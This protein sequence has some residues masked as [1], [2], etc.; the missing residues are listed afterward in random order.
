M[1]ILELQKALAK[2][3]FDPGPADGISGPKTR[4]AIK[5]FQT[6]HGLQVDGI[7]GP[8][9][10]AKLFNLSAKEVTAKK[11]AGTIIGDVPAD[12]A[13]LAEAKRLIGTA[14]I[15]GSGNSPV[16][17]GMA[18]AADIAF[19]NDE[20]PWC[21]LFVAH[22]ISS[23]IPEEPMPANPLGARQWMKFG[24]PVD[25]Q[26]GSVLVFWR[27]SPSG[28]M[29][30]VGFYWAEDDLHYHVL[31]GNQSNSVNVSK[32]SKSRLLGAT[33]PKAIPPVGIRRMSTGASL[34]LST[35]EQ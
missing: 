27:G 33:W 26:F 22:C 30:H 9:T 5:G 15:A 13:W 31:G 29:G 23:T 34:V 28:W 17:M 8:K 6:K 3:G 10:M 11:N 7:A 4:A 25:P 1:T 18:D 16:I 19:A 12:M 14:E 32:M 2:A 21:G 20:T 24:I 35:N